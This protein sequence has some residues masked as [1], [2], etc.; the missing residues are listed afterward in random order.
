MPWGRGVFPVEDRGRSV[1]RTLA[2]LASQ[3]KK[4]KKARA[5]ALKSR[6]ASRWRLAACMGSHVVVGSIGE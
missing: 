4:G 5:R 1:S 6:G 2:R 3:V